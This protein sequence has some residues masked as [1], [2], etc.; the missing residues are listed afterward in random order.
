MV[1]PI[2]RP[3]ILDPDRINSDDREDMTLLEHRDRAQQL[4][5]ALHESCAY[6]EMLWEHLDVARRY[7]YESLPTDPRK[8]GDDPHLGASPT[9]PDDEQGWA[10]WMDIYAHVTSA[11][12]GPHGDSGFG[13]GEARRAARD[14]REA[15]NLLVTAP[16]AARRPE[17]PS[18]PDVVPPRPV[19]DTPGSASWLR[20]ARGAGLGALVV[21]AGRGL[22]PRRAR[23][24]D[25]P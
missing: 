15:A 12:A 23:H 10:Q 5:K 22:L 16:L 17:T 7:L 24:W 25:T 4:D 21:L 2:P 20:I 8:P 11:L 13:L 19:P 18:Q 14:R 9:G 3:S 1:Q 6:A